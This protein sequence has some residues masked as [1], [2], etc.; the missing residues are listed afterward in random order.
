MAVLVFSKFLVLL[1]LLL[2]LLVVVVVV[3][4][5]VVFLQRLVP[6]DEDGDVSVV[7]DVVADGA[8]ESAPDLAHAPC[9][10]HDARHALRFRR[11]HDG[12]AG[13]AVQS[14]QLAADLKGR[15]ET[16]GT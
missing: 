15:V 5:V 9:A 11:L 3:V 1:L 10:R 2:L 14:Q 13:L 4:T 12:V 16:C 7:Q 6:A 8:Q